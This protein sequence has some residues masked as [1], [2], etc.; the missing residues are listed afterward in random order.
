MVKIKA[1]VNTLFK[2]INNII[3]SPLDPKFRKLP[4]ENEAVRN[5]VLNHNGAVEFLK[6]AG[7]DM[8][9]DPKYA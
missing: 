8:D 6:I 9:A 7:F 1:S 5:K 3:N 4:K 2:I